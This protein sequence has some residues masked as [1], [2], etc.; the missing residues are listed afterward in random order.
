MSYE[1]SGTFI[2]YAATNFKEDR[3]RLIH[4]I[5]E[6][7]RRYHPMPLTVRQIHYRF[8]TNNWA[9]N[10]AKT[11]NMIQSAVSDGRMNGLISWDAI[12]DRNRYLKGLS[13]F[14]SL[15]E[16]MTDLHTNYRRDLWEDQP[17][18][19]EV[20][21][22]KAALEGV[23]AGICNQLRVNYYSQ[24]GYNSQSEH[25]HAGRRFANYIR[26]GQQVILFHLGDHDPSGVDMTRSNR[27]KLEMFAGVPINVQRLALN[28][29]QIEEHNL[30][31]QFAKE[32]DPRSKGY[33]KRFGD[34][35]WELDALDPT[36]IVDLITK[37][38]LRVRDETIW[39]QAVIREAEEKRYLKELTEGDRSE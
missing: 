17:M 31:P 19:A 37:A 14:E 9:P 16:A 20:W 30:A 27:E 10:T 32:S 25:W 11:Y 39:G 7:I 4:R 35:S 3:L 23:I 5:N 13:T 18:R 22:E 26:K 15:R 36:M 28:M 1:E 12:E 2:A 24:R 29:N 6:V 34:Q 21:I 33:K 38:V 8:V